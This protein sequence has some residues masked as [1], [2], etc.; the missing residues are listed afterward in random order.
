MASPTEAPRKA[1]SRHTWVPSM[2]PFLCGLAT[3]C[4]SPEAGRRPVTRRGQGLQAFLRTR[5]GAVACVC[6]QGWLR[7]AGTRGVCQAVP[8]GG[9]VLVLSVTAPPGPVR[10]RLVILP[11]PCGHA[12]WSSRAAPGAALVS[13]HIRGPSPTRWVQLLPQSVN[14]PL[15]SLG[16]P[17]PWPG[18]APPLPC[19]PLPADP[20]GARPE[21]SPFVGSQSL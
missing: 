11:R 12:R 6:V 17:A 20:G 2:R 9:C 7:S 21:G 4:T 19:T 10:V 14:S 16:R 18:P 13:G 3:P 1:C 5:W 15:L 8:L